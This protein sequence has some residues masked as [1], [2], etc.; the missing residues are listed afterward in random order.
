MLHSLVTEL[1]PIPR[2]L[3]GE[4]VRETLRRLREIVPL[5]IREVPSGTRV[6]DWTV[7]KEWNVREAWIR[8]PRGRTVV[9]FRDCNL[10]V[11][12]YSVPVHARL[13]RDELVRHVHTLPDHPD[14]IPYRT[15]YYDESWGFCMAHRQLEALEQGEYEVRI[16]ASLED[17]GLTYGEC[18]LTGELDEEI[19][20]SCHV[21]H[22]ALANDNLSGIAVATYLAKGLHERPRRYSYRFLFVPGTIGSIAWLALN[23]GALRRIRGGLVLAG[24][25]DPGGLTYKRSRRGD[26]EIDRAAAHVLRHSGEEHD[27]QE[28]IP[29]GYDERQYCSPG[30]DLPVGCLMRTPWGTYPEYHTSADDPGLVRPESLAGSLAVCRAIVEV[31]EGN[32]TYL[33]LSPKGEPQLGRRGLYDRVGGRVDRKDRI[34]ALLWV[35]NLSD[36]GQDLLAIADRA[37]MPFGRVRWAADALL[38]AGLLEER[39]P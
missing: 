14:W 2:S 35:L 10:H 15:S 19:L 30:F 5:E 22:P 21:C 18:Y 25:G 31:L 24:V 6:L 38:D 1:F 26:A 39:R 32:R 4:G 12:G 7:P 27:V 11:V 36:G 28:F 9:D 33:N 20:I 3:T 23:E 16:D 34:L 29:Y 13:P 37:G 17:G 8:D